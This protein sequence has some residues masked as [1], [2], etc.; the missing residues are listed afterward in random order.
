[1]NILTRNN[2]WIMPRKVHRSVIP[3]HY[4]ASRKVFLQERTSWKI[5]IYNVE[6]ISQGQLYELCARGYETEI[7]VQIHQ[8]LWVNELSKIEALRSTKL[9]ELCGF[10]HVLESVPHGSKHSRSE[11]DTL[12]SIDS[13]TFVPM[14]TKCGIHQPDSENTCNG[15]TK[16]RKLRTGSN[17]TLK[18]VSHGQLNSDICAPGSTKFWGMKLVQ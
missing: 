12:R 4:W 15:F 2:A 1:M 7:C 10:N 17:E 16:L 14:S 8:I 13:E 6:S 3:S 5:G 11:I 9:G 18:S